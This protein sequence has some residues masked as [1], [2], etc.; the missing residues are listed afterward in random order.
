M[1]PSW[2]KQKGFLYQIDSYRALNIAN[3]GVEYAIR[4][5]SDGLT[6]TTNPTNNFF[7]NHSTSVTRSFAGGTFVFTYDHV[8]NRIA[9]EGSYPDPSPQSR[10]EVRLSN[11]RRYFS[12]ISLKPDGLL[13]SIP[14][15]NLNDIDIPTISNND[16]SFTVTRIDVSITTSSNMYLNILRD[17]TAIFSNSGSVPYAP[18]LPTPIPVCYNL[19]NGIY[20][21]S[22]NYTYRFDL[23]SPNPNHVMDSTPIYTLHFSGPPPTGLYRI[24]FYTSLSSTPYTI[25]FSI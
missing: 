4:Y 2:D 14:Q 21:Y 3:A 9:V 16:S 1:S 10:R 17:G 5:V 15:R 8:N 20:T 24:D 12:P 18:C 19:A 25:Q 6:D 23:T 13:A 7:S 11:V 22:G